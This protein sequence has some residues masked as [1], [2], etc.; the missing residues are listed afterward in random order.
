MT[1]SRLANKDGSMHPTDMGQG[2]GGNRTPM[3]NQT[4]TKGGGST[5]GSTR[6]TVLQGSR[7]T[8]YL[9]TSMKHTI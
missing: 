9:Q 3:G 7:N 5:T 2:G 8:E 6:A 1:S 4:G